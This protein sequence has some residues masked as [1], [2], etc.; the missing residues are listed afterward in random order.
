FLPHIT[1]IEHLQLQ[2]LPKPQ[3]KEQTRPVNFKLH[4]EE[5]A[6]RRAG[7]NDLVASKIYSLEILK[8]FEEK[9]QKVIEEEE[10]KILRKEMV[11]KAQ[12]MP[13]FDKP[14]SPQRSRRPL[15]VPRE[16][17]FL[18]RESC[19]GDEGFKYYQQHFGQHMKAIR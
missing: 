15:T 5:R 13:F 9:I 7:F 10:I 3:V 18:H 8:R 14:F 6:T 19:S 11:P 12:L 16:P 2:N 1:K 4:T 17:S